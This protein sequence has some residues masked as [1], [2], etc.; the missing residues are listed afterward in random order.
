M[1]GGSNPPCPTKHNYPTHNNLYEPVLG[2]NRR[3]SGH[4]CGSASS[5]PPPDAAAQAPTHSDPPSNPPATMDA[6]RD[7]MHNELIS[8]AEV[9]ARLQVWLATIGEVDVARL[10][11]GADAVDLKSRHPLRPR[12]RAGLSGEPRA[13]TDRAEL[14]ATDHGV[15]AGRPRPAREC[16]QPHARLLL[17]S[18]NEDGAPS[19]RGWWQGS[20]ASPPYRSGA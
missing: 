1:V 9:A 5:P 18:A 8:R 6:E 20:R 13:A 3:S 11:S 14:A 12:R 10:V 17:R 7:G 4:T 19:T 16:R 2:A 15:T